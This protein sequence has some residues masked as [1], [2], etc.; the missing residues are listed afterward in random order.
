LRYN[1]PLPQKRIDLW[2]IKLAFH[3]LPILASLHRALLSYIRAI[4][5]LSPQISVAILFTL[6]QPMPPQLLVQAL[7]I[8]VKLGAAYGTIRQSALIQTNP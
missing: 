1:A 6:H 8:K 7:R 5:G 4:Q 2:L 3:K